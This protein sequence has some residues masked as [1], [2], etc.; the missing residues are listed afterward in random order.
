MLVAEILE[1]KDPRIIAIQ[2]DSVV[3]ETANVLKQERIGVA[4]VRESD[5]SLV[6]I[7]SERDIVRCVAEHGEAALEK[8]V[9][10]LMSRD[11]ITCTPDS[12]TE[13]LIEKMLA[14]KVRHLPVLKGHALVGVVSV[15]DVMKSVL[16]E[17]KWREQVLRDHVVAATGWATDDD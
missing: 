13:E 4:L 8:S 12:S 9:A 6:G 1:S 7:I 15:N 10:E 5:G 2:P 11:V 3:R 16:G 17:L 14:N